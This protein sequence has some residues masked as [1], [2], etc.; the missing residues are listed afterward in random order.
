MSKYKAAFNRLEKAQVV[1]KELTKEYVFLMSRSEAETKE[2][3]VI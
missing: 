2:R 1:F 3:E